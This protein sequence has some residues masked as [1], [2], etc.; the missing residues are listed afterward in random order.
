MS[1]LLKK[2]WTVLASSNASVHHI[3]VYCSDVWR[4]WRSISTG[5]RGRQS[6]LPLPLL[7]FHS[8][9][10][11]IPV[12][13]L[14]GARTHQCMLTMYS[15]GGLQ[16]DLLRHLTRAT[17]H[18]ASKFVLSVSLS[19]C[20][21]SIHPS[22]SVHCLFLYFVVFIFS[23][24]IVYQGWSWHPQWFVGSIRCRRSSTSQKGMYFEKNYLLKS[25]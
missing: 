11:T 4:C 25:S 2:N 3:S 14:N 8:M 16:W 22:L 7:S 13:Q 24:L 19:I 10:T 9:L 6:M 5:W 23:M 21:P 12:I 15:M 20:A 1:E 17:P 18:L